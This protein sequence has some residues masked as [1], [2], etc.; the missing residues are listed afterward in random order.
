[1]LRSIPRNHGEP[2]RRFRGIAVRRG[3][4]SFDGEVE[5]KR[6]GDSYV[7]MPQLVCS[8]PELRVRWFHRQADEDVIGSLRCQSSVASVSY[9]RVIP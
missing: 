5:A 8:R 3:G 9:D 7:F 6:L 4:D 1:V 2:L